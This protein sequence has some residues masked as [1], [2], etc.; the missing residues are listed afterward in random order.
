MLLHVIC[1]IA[2]RTDDTNVFLPTFAL[3]KGGIWTPDRFRSVL[4]PGERTEWNCEGAPYTYE[5]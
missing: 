3:Q 5:R 4:F 1:V 2:Y